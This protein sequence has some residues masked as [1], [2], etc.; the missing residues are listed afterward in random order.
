M[1][2]K[3]KVQLRLRYLVTSHV[4]HLYNVGHGNYGH[5]GANGIRLTLLT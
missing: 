2:N 3:H 5:L 4:V 1:K